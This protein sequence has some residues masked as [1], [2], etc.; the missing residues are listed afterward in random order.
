MT[1]RFTQLGRQLRKLRHIV[2]GAPAAVPMTTLRRA[3]QL[4]RD[5]ACEAAATDDGPAAFRELGV[6]GM[7]DPALAE[8]LAG[9]AA[10]AAER[11]D[12]IGANLLAIGGDLDRFLRSLEAGAPAPELPFE[13]LVARER[14]KPDSTAA[15]VISG[16]IVELDVRGGLAVV[17]VDEQPIA[18]TL[19]SGEVVTSFALAAA[20]TSRAEVHRER[21]GETRVEWTPENVVIELA[22]DFARVQ[23]SIR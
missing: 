2:G 9:Y 11:D 23:I 10:A 16:R 7:L 19:P 5:L 1:G 3:T 21:T 8:R 6:R 4:A 18:M 22:P 13:T 20:P 15:V 14:T 17:A 12:S